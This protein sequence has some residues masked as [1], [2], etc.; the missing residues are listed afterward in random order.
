ML[1]QRP[2]L[3]HMGRPT[4]DLVVKGATAFAFAGQNG[5]G[6]PESVA[7]QHYPDAPAVALV[8]RGAVTPT[9]TGTAAAL[10]RESVEDF[11]LSLAG[12]SAAAA[13]LARASLPMTLDRV[14][15]IRAPGRLTS[16]AD[17]G[18]FVREGE[19][20]RVLGLTLAG[21]LLTPAKLAVIYTFTSELLGYG[22]RDA[23]ALVRQVL[24][25][26]SALALDA[27][28][29]GDAAAV[30][31]LRPAGLLYGVDPL[32]AAAGGGL[33]AMLLDV[34]TLGDAIG[35]AGGGTDLAFIAS[36]GMALGLKLMAGPRFD[37]PVLA[38]LAVPGDR[39]IAL[40]CASLA[41]AYGAVPRFD[42]ADQAVLHMEDAAPAQIG[43]PGAPATVA[44]PSR[45]LWQTDTTALRMILPIDWAMR[46]AGHVAFV[47]GVTW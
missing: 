6:S 28:M 14:D 23:E 16:A 25:E 17:A 10:A 3:P 7:A 44:A 9:S 15:R 41:A 38:S 43:T 22:V 8:A 11:T 31:E 45:S 33:D 18:T 42:S 1:A 30:D 4:G 36:P 37:Y 34:R 29:L 13:L 46:A 2:L 47:D 32:P 35:L 39:L 21:P 19:P 20:I 5:L 40:D 24:T 27:A 12:P 26:A